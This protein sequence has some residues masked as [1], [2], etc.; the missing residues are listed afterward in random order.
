MKLAA[1][2]VALVGGVASLKA[3]SSH[4]VKLEGTY[5]LSTSVLV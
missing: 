3:H 4:T 1:I 5:D 2:I